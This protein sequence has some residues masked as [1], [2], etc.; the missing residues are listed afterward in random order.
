VLFIIISFVISSSFFNIY[1]I[2][3]D[4]LFVCMVVD[5]QENGIVISAPDSLKEFTSGGYTRVP[6]D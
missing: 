5:R 3:A 2:A 1:G 6:Q 4:T